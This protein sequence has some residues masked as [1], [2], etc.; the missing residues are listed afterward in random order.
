MADDSTNAQVKPDTLPNQSPALLTIPQLAYGIKQ[1]IPE[2]QSLP[3]AA[4]ARRALETHPE[5]IHSIRTFEPR[6][7][8]REQQ[9]PS[10]SPPETEIKTI[11][12]NKQFKDLSASEKARVL[13][14]GFRAY[15]QREQY[16]AADST[17]WLSRATH[18]VKSLMGETGG[19]AISATGAMAEPKTAATAATGIIDPA[20]PATIFAAQG[21][22]ALPGQIKEARAHPTPENV[23][24]P[25]ATGGMV[26]A[27]TA[28]AVEGAQ[29][30]GPAVTEKVSTGARIVSQEIAG[31]GRERVQG[32]IREHGVRVQEREAAHE[33]EVRRVAESNAEAANAHSKEVERVASENAEATAAYREKLADSIA[34]HDA[35]VEAIKKQYANDVAARERK[36]AELNAQHA[37]KVAKARAEWVQKAYESKQAGRE[38]AKVEARREALKH[39]QDAY[40]KLVDENV[41]ATHKAVRGALDERW[42]G[43]RE[44]VGVDAPVKAPPLYDA[45]EKGRAM[46]AGVPADLKIFND[47]VKEITEKGEKV[48]TEEG[49]LRS[50]PKESIPF[51]DA[52]TQFSAIGEKAYAAEGNLR[53]ALF[54]L[55]DAY[56]KGLN[57]TADAA[58]AGKEYGALKGDWK[59]YMQDW[60]DMRSQA[61]G[62]SPLARLYRAVDDPIVA[63]QVVGKFGDR[64]LETFARYD[65]YGAAPTLMSKLRNLNAVAKSLPKVKVPAMPGKLETPAAPKLPGEVEPPEMVAPP[66]EIKA[67]KLKE[68]PEAPKPKVAEPVKPVS[69]VNAFHTRLTEIE[70]FTGSPQ[71]FFDYAVPW[72]IA[73]KLLL[74]NA[75]FKEWVASQPRSSDP[76]FVPSGQ[77]GAPATR[78]QFEAAAKEVSKLNGGGMSAL[79]DYMRNSIT[80]DGFKQRLQ[81]LFPNSSAADIE[82]VAASVDKSRSAAGG[83]KTGGGA[84]GAGASAAAPKGNPPEPTGGGSAGSPK[85]APPAPKS[86]RPGGPVA[87]DELE[88]LRRGAGGEPPV[89]PV[90]NAIP[91]EQRAS[92]VIAQEERENVTKQMQERVKAKEELEK[93]Q[94]SKTGG[95]G[96]TESGP[97]SK[98]L[99]DLLDGLN[100]N[101]VT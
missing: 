101:R 73:D 70:N 52:R 54:T 18:W 64:L 4:V 93:E 37:D 32:E 90:E 85:P 12:G 95:K 83:G 21:G 25:L 17:G 38:L 16:K 13:A 44:K 22:L 41:K 92:A 34:E 39:G 46:L 47:I 20:I 24:A 56:D 50:V 66:K 60:H 49:E 53:R 57:A 98:L 78:A 51:D 33:A 55:Y 68:P 80:R 88:M 89:A 28:G 36:I 76:D 74:K 65:K 100:K 75:R 29:R 99:D 42:N 40:T 19:L 96:G 59:N 5:L 84:A 15:A 11:L 8:M 26:A 2:L 86:P 63:A 67:P 87:E 72:R 97:I 45:V 79:K 3:D 77:R 61:T 69:P 31:A 7:R 23:Q 1:R 10:G 82:A 27:G 48:E 71:T 81:A 62:G 14:L 6:G 91:A 35:K 94:K 58:G 43:L 30:V 9:A